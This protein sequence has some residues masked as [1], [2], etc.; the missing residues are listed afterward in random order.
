M[1]RPLHTPLCELLG[2]RHPILLAGMAGG[3]TTPE[4]VA[5]VSQ[6]GGLGV[7]GATGMTA[8]A[9]GEAVRTACE[10]TG[11]P[12]G[13]NVLVAPPTEGNPHPDAV[14]QALAP[15]RRE[16]G[17]PHP[18]PPSPVR[19]STAIEL[20]EAGLAAGA[21]VLSVGLGDPAT[22]APIARSAG[23]PLLAM[24]S[25]VED[26]VAAA[27]AGADVI[28]AQGAEAGGHRSNF[29]LGPRGEVPLIGTMALVPQVVAA[30]D[31]PVVAAGGIMDGRGLVAALALGAA[32]AQ[33]GTLFLATRE[34]G[35]SD[36]Y[37][38]R[39]VSAADTDTLVTAAVT[40]RPARMLRSRLVQ[41]MIEGPQPLGWPRQA[42]A[43]MDVRAAADRAGRGDLAVHLAGQAAGMSPAGRPGAADVVMSIIDEALATIERLSD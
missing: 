3:P 27:G 2:L 36:L 1:K 19:P 34:S 31:V 15:F 39:V 33:Y 26:A 37:K 38:D 7:F 30:V 24:A 21:R 8:D 20:V 22:I 35:A 32:G 16:L 13:V 29:T 9:L 28:V 6:A 4:L 23:V 5:A 18:A 17:I 12:V 42:P 10:L 11:A 25:T 41:S 43:T 40:G 14:Q